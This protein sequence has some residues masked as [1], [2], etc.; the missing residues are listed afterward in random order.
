MTDTTASLITREPKYQEIIRDWQALWSLEQ[1]ERQLRIS[2]RRGAWPRASLQRPH[3][4]D[5]L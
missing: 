4:D 3:R 5:R 1:T 2:Q